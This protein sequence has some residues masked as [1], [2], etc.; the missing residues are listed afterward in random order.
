MDESA[1][2]EVVPMRR[3]GADAAP[4]DHVSAIPSGDRAEGAEAAEAESAAESAGVPGGGEARVTGRTSDEAL[5][6]LD[7]ADVLVGLV[8]V[9]VARSRRVADR[10]RDVA[11]PLSPLVR[12]VRSLGERLLGA[13][14]VQDVLGLGRAQRLEAARRGE[15]VVRRFAPRLVD[16]ALGLVDL[17]TLVQD[18][19]D[20][21][22]LAAG[23]DVDAV[24]ARADIEAVLDRVDIDAVAARIDIEA[25]LDRVDIDGVAARIDIEAILDRVDIDGVAA[26][27][28]IEAILDRVDIDGVAARI[29][30]EAILDRVDI[31]GVAA[32]ID[33]EAILDRVDIDGVA[34][35]IDIEAILDRVDI[36]AVA[37]RLDLDAVAARLDIDA[38]VARIDLIALAE[39]VVEGIDLPGIIQSSTG[40]MAS[41]S[42][43]E[44]RWQG[45]SADERVAHVVDRMLHR[46]PRAPG[47][48]LPTDTSSVPSA[49]HGPVG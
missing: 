2:G 9:S 33:I 11:R 24:V 43:R 22:A 27:I 30:I 14:R 47:A 25:I 34:A 35:R 7:L 23:L 1:A 20:L 5:S 26:R 12:P 32:R 3:P 18:H 44:V 29:D 16:D 8:A 15:L 40:A 21:D 17:T 48:A 4:T 28:D 19:V 6:V 42:L 39:Y 13:D 46:K 10:V 36:D 45:V 41:E 38:V 31:D 49:L 37:T